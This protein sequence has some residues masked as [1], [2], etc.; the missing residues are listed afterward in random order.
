LNLPVIH[1]HTKINAPLLVCFDLSRSIDLHI[2]STI[3][4]G[5]YVIAGR[6][7][8]LI[9]LHET[10]T[11]RARHFGIWQTLTSKIT[12]FD[13]PDFFTDEMV[14]GAFKSFRHEHHFAEEDGDTTMKDIFEF[15]TPFGIFGK[16]AE[17]LFLKKYMERLLTERNMVIKNCAEGNAWKQ[18]LS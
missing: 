12:E 2:A 10:V 3:K 17:V 7:S 16:L 9:C 8:G 5:E 14:N 4:T 11:W 13:S 1:L 15:Q 6:Q 18:Y